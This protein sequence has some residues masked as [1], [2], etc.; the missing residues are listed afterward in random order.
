MQGEISDAHPNAHACRCKIS[1]VTID[2]PVTC[3]WKIHKELAKYISKLSHVSATC[4]LNEDEEKQLLAMCDGP[5]APE[6]IRN[7]RAYLDALDRRREEAPVWLPRRE[8]CDR[9]TGHVD[10]S[11][12]A[13]TPQDWANL[14]VTYAPP[15][16]L[17]GDEALKTIVRLWPVI[18]NMRGDGGKL[19]FLF[20]YH[21]S[22]ES[23]T[24]SLPA[25]LTFLSCPSRWCRC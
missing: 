21:V 22:H 20:I 24:L 10:R 4:R 1:L 9:W 2:S 12:F 11:I 16:M 6:I 25:L 13:T 5:Q 17:Q 18:E 23:S 15:A 8:A 19:G 3:P 7:R 14:S